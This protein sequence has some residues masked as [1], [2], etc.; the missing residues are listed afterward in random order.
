MKKR[1][2]TKKFNNSFF[3]SKFP[4]I[5]AGL[6]LAALLS[7]LLVYNNYKE[8]FVIDI[9]GYMIGDVNFD[10]LKND[11]EPEE[12]V[13]IKTV[14]VASEEAILKNSFNHYIS[15]KEKTPVNVDYP[16]YVNDGLA[17]IN[18][19]DNINLLNS[20]FDRTTGHTNLVLSYGKIYDSVTYTQIDKESYLFLSY[21]DGIF[22]NLYDVKIETAANEYIIPVNSFIYFFE[23][24]L[25]YYARVDGQFKRGVIEDVDFNSKVTFYYHG[26]NEKFEYTYEEVI[27]LTGSVYIAEEPELKP[28]EPEVQEPEIEEEV[29]EKPKPNRKPT[30]VKPN[31][32]PQEPTVKYWEKPSVKSSAFTSNVYSIKGKIEVND[33]AGVIVKQPTYTLYVNNKVSTRRTYYQTGEVLISGLSSETEYIVVGQYTYLDSDF[34]TRKI[35]TF[36]MGSVKTKDRSNLEKI[37]LTFTPG[38]IYSKKIELNGV[39]ITSEL[40]SEAI[41]GVKKIGLKIEDETFIL[42]SSLTKSILDGEKVTISTNES[43]KSN[44]IINFEIIFYDR[45]NNVITTQNNK[46]TTRTCKKPPTLFLKTIENDSINMKISLDLRNDD[47]VK[48]QNYRYTVTNSAGKIVSSGTIN[49]SYIEVNNLDPNQVFKLRVYANIDLEDGNGYVDNF[50]LAQMDIVTLPIS[51]LGFIN[52]RLEAE[53]ITSN[54]A[55]IKVQINPNKTDSRLIKLLQKVI[56]YVYDIETN[57]LITT[58]TIS[59]SSV[60]SLK[61]GANQIIELSDLESNK[62]YRLEFK[63]EVIQ[64]TTEY[65]LDCIYQ[66]ESF[67]TRKKSAQV[68]LTNMFTTNSMIDFDVKVEDE[69]GAVLSGEVLIELRDEKKNL[70]KTTIIK[71]NE[72]TPQRIT[73]NDLEAYH[74]YTLTF[75]A[76]EYN[77][78][79]NNTEYSAKYQLK[80]LEVYTEEGISGQVELISSERK[81]TGTNLIDVDSELKWYQTHYWYN[82]PKTVDEE[83]DM[84]IYAKN[85]AAAY[86]FNLEDYEGELISVSFKIRAVNAVDPR[87]KVYVTNLVYG[88][89]STSWSQE[90]TNISSTWRTV[91]YKFVVGS[92]YTPSTNRYNVYTTKTYGQNLANF[93]GFYISGGTV[94][95]AEY[96]IRD[97]EAHIATADVEHNVDVEVEQGQYSTSKV[98]TDSGVIARTEKLIDLQGG[99]YY[100]FLH[101]VGESVIYFYDTTGKYVRSSGWAREGQTFYL[102]DDMQVLIQFRH[103]EANTMMNPHEVQYNIRK[104]KELDYTVPYEKF[105]YSLVTRVKVNVIDLRKEI[106]KNDYYIKVYEDG[107]EVK[108]Y[109][110]VELVGTDRIID[111]EKE[112]DLQEKKHYTIELGVKVRDRYYAIDHF[113][114]STDS[115]VKGISTLDDIYYMQPKGNY[116][117]LNDLSMKGYTAERVG[118]GY[119]YFYGTIDFQGYTVSTYASTES[120]G[121]EFMGR[122]EKSGVLKNL[123]LDVHYDQPYQI[124]YSSGFIT[125][126][127]GTIENVYINIHNETMSNLTNTYVSPLAVTN[128]ASG[129]IS[130]FVVNIKNQMNLYYYSSMLV[131]DNYGLIE[132]GY[133]YGADIEVDPEYTDKNARIGLIQVYGGARSTVRRVY[134]L[135]SMKYRENSPLIGGLISYET[136]G[137]TENVYTIGDS[138]ASVITNGPLIGH[139]QAT[140]SHNKLYYMNKATYTST[141]QE[142][143]NATALNDE[144]FQEDLLGEGFNVE[145]YVKIGYYPQVEWTSNKMPNQPYLELPKLLEDNLVDIV[146]MKILEQ[147]NSSAIVE[148]NVSN[149][150]GDNIT[151]IGISD[152]DVQI[153]SQTYEDGTSTVQ[154]KLTNP[155]TFISKYEIRNIS[156]VNYLG[157]G[158]TRTYVTGEKYANVAFY[159]EIFDIDDWSEINNGLGQNYAI[160]DDLDFY[161]YQDIYIDNFTGTIEGNNH[162]LKNISITKSGKAGLFKQMNGVMQNITF[163]KFTHKANATQAGIVGYS[164]QYAR[165]YNVHIKTANITMADDKTSDTYYAGALVGQV[166]A[167][168][169][170]DCTATNVNIT[171]DKPISGITVGGLVGYADSINVTNAYVQNV[172]IMITN[173]TSTN[174][175]GGIVGRSASTNAIIQNTY[176][177]GDIESNN[178]YT[179]GI[180]GNNSGSIDNSYSSVN[181]SSELGYIGG[182]TGYTSTDNTYINNNLYVGNIYTQKEGAKIVPNIAVNETNFSLKTSLI[183]GVPTDLT[184]G[185]ISLTYA[186]LQNY[187]TYEETIGFADVYEYEGVENGILPKLHYLDRDDLLPNQLD[188]KIYIDEL[189]IYEIVIGNKTSSDAIIVVYVDNPN[190]YIIEDVKI[191][192]A[193]TVIKSQVDEDG[194]SIITVEVTPTRY[195]DNYKLSGLTFKVTED[196]EPQTVKKE[197]RLELTF[198]KQIKSY[199]DWQAISK[200]YAENYILAADLDFTD[201]TDINT[202]V[203]INRLETQSASDYKTIKG[204]EI[205][206]KINKSAVT[207]IDKVL[208]KMSNITFEDITINDTSTGA[209]NYV[210]IIMFNYAELD[211]I[212]FKNVTINA[213]KEDY[214]APIGRNYAQNIKNITAEDITITGRHYAAGV[215]SY[216][217]NG[218]GRTYENI[219]AT[220]INVTGS[221]NYAGG[222]FAYMPIANTDAVYRVNYL[223]I[224]DSEIHSTGTGSTYTGGIGGYGDCSNCTVTNTKVSGAIYVGGV[225]GYQ[226]STYAKDLEVY[227]S[228]ITGTARYIGGIGG[229]TRTLSNAYVDNTKVHLNNSEG[230][231]AGGISGY[232]S[233]YYLRSAGVNNSQ[234]DGTGT[235]IGGLIGR[236]SGGE[237]HTSYV[238]NSTIN[239]RSYVGGIAGTHKSNWILRCK[240]A[241]STVHATYSHAGGLIGYVGEN[242]LSS[243]YARE[244]I[245][246]NVDVSS[247]REAGG[248][249]GGLK[250]SLYY[251]EYFYSLYF[252]GNVTSEENK[253]GFATGDEHDSEI[254]QLQRIV[255]YENATVNGTKVNEVSEKTTIGENLLKN[256]TIETGYILGSDGKQLSDF[257]YPNGGYTKEFIQLKAGKTYTLRVKTNGG[258]DWMRAKI[259]SMDETF[260]SD[261]SSASRR[262]YPRAYYFAYYDTVTFRV[263]QDCLIRVMFYNA[264]QIDAYYLYENQFGP[265][266]I[267]TDQLVDLNELKMQNTWTRYINSD[268]AYDYVYSSKLNLDY[269][270][271]DFSNLNGEVTN[272]K[273]T[274]QSDNKRTAT[275]RTDGILDDGI[276]FD[277]K[278]DEVVIDGYQATQD[279][280]ITMN[281]KPTSSTRLP[282]Q[283][284]FTTEQF[285]Q[286]GN[287]IGVFLH[288]RQIYVRMNGSNTAIPVYVA[289]NSPV[290][291]TVTYENNKELKV[292]KNGRLEYTNSNIKRTLNSPS[293]VAKIS[294]QYQYSNGVRYNGVYKSL[295]VYNRA[296]SSDEVEDNYDAGTV[297]TKDGLE[298]HYDF[299]NLENTSPTGYY[300]SLYDYYN[301]SVPRYQTLTELP[302]ED[303]RT[304]LNPLV[305]TLQTEQTTQESLVTGYQLPVLNKAIKDIYNI[306]PSGINNVNIEFDNVYSDVSFKYK[307]GKYESEKIKTTDN[308]YTLSYDF[309][310]DL[311]ITIY[312]RNDEKTI[313]LKPEELAKTIKIVD[314]KFYHIKDNKL[315]E[316]DKKLVDNAYNIYNNIV[317]LDNNKVYSISTNQTTDA[318]LTKGILKTSRPLA[319]YQVEDNLVETYYNFSK[320]TDFEGKTAIRDSQLHI[321]D[322]NLYVFNNTANTEQNMHVF[323][324]YNTEDYQISLTNGNLISIKKEINY[325]GYFN[326]N[327]IVEVDHDIN[328]QEPVIMIKYQNGYV[329]AFDYYRGKELFAYG[330]KADISLVSFII[331]SLSGDY[332]L[333]SSNTTFKESNKLKETLINVTNDEVKE[334]LEVNK[335]EPLSPSD[336]TGDEDIPIASDSQYGESTKEEQKLNNSYVQVYNPV[337]DEYEVYNTQ[338]L[339]ST[340]QEVI[341]SSESRI[342]NDA[343]LYNYFYG[344]KKNRFFENSKVTI[345][346][347]IV[348]IIIINLFIIAKRLNIKEVKSS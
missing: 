313:T 268:K 35:V 43:L 256:A 269:N 211:N 254:H 180:V 216:A 267:N 48:F 144:Y 107:Q 215:I 184:N 134:T 335:K 31:Y 312:S 223:T 154:A 71:T 25:N 162:T 271:F 128:Y 189:N 311:E 110:Y 222:I 75:Y 27:T 226:I 240:V 266:G 26:G 336:K 133:I 20:D 112:I 85:G 160:M 51:S 246:A 9:D 142:K 217:E 53:D 275:I 274:D 221:S 273:V 8:V 39:G 326:N 194:K 229:Y 343:F 332:A 255:Y 124:N 263:F 323:N 46:G 297:V 122:V 137:H 2:N 309:K 291:I 203:V 341:T 108:S 37:N 295:S 270:Y 202:N 40:D 345:I 76:N 98:K 100:Q 123:V 18:Y 103:A 340:E 67:T 199:E 168:K 186:D 88:S 47:N 95:L 163:E 173:S 243:V 259:Y 102:K 149:P 78:T 4:I 230:Y 197:N 284:L 242:E 171:S 196:A 125:Y 339:L 212:K 117:L 59:G 252:E 303:N 347:I 69:D 41:R 327:G 54:A 105:Q 200:E 155:K 206:N 224:S 245:V 121:L 141:Y 19:N 104:M 265:Y 159:K 99:Y 302:T 253:A 30:V 317:L 170:Q 60:D 304:Y 36:Y 6:L 87:Y 277:G 90:I 174:G 262:Y 258:T 321:K 70:V 150:A 153:E 248:L 298:L 316:N 288:Y 272:M 64:G 213:K 183:N 282:Y 10:D 109:N 22:I 318:I 49:G 172:N 301:L 227:D 42:S 190:Q 38:A 169:I 278:N 114:I 320:I 140:A 119:R 93:V 178:V 16:L 29:V 147:T 334:K 126:N 176:S 91:T 167:S 3:A 1:Q 181:L 116:I 13:Q 289:T 219:S 115:E 210:N 63:S 188:N 257:D 319:T 325:P 260:V 342:K 152:L 157:Y 233:G 11:K 247:T 280:T 338:E 84:H 231:G 73:Y 24:Q 249:F 346:L 220:R 251:P 146:S 337:T 182:I 276:F 322:N 148:F 33:P 92:S 264:Q 34:K 192:D 32:K 15:N 45:E 193:E 79:K 324:N 136:Y 7:F 12:P 72:E 244:N 283:F 279:Y 82:I 158:S 333:A 207:L 209:N 281:F 14:E 56:L 208:S 310:N 179:G 195:Y 228:E 161:G 130:N 238:Q 111:A 329:L 214:V 286:S 138:N 294:P 300:P 61:A 234:I 83:G 94:D 241:E 296:L 330:E 237:T 101:N 80:K 118:W 5:I 290:E 177:T 50:E 74:N 89:T 165:F 164:N 28:I 187:L 62:E 236:Q 166:K 81:T 143:I 348:F 120:E 96:E 55:N 305:N 344:N 66:L 307:N 151:K 218:E 235:E 86:T 44:S 239:G 17:I 201:K 261:L 113:E 77:E 308:V 97:L 225:L 21:Q 135:P 204:I 156:S 145:D 287:G 139:S 331:D 185:E 299:S 191:D 127:Y 57:K 52:L 285:N 314:N 292:Y 129:R 58:K 250:Y 306:Y 106:T 315:Y 131:R 205:N 293:T 65:T 23:D 175:A 232:R 328:S 68:L 198:Y 132:D